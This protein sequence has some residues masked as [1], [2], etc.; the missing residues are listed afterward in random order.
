MAEGGN[1]LCRIEAWVKWYLEL[2]VSEDKD[3]I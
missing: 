3:G 1:N 2:N